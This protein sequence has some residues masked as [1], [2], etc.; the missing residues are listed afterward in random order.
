MDPLQGIPAQL[1]SE[2]RQIWTTEVAGGRAVYDKTGSTIGRTG[3]WKVSRLLRNHSIVPDTDG[4]WERVR[5]HG[6]ELY[7]GRLAP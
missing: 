5:A 7:F 2:I 1:H 4:R 6:Q 3:Q